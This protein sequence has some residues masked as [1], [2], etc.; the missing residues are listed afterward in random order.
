MPLP[1]EYWSTVFLLEDPPEPLPQDFAI[2]TAWNPEG[3]TAGKALNEMA[4]HALRRELEELGLAPFRVTGCSPDLSHREPGWG[5]VISKVA[6]VALGRR[7]R[8]LGIWRVV[9]DGLILVDCATAAESRVAT[10]SARI[11]GR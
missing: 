4:D 3:V 11:V 5:V 6:A 2:I 1:P 9:D 7:H 10:F 8:Q